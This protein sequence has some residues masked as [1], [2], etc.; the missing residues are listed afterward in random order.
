MGT[1]VAY[2]AGKLARDHPHVIEELKAGKYK[3]VHAAAIAAGVTPR[4]IKLSATPESFARQA[5]HYFD[6]AQIKTLI[7]LL[8]HPERLPHP[9]QRG[10]KARVPVPVAHAS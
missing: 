2:L 7:H 9:Q 5:H 3:S 4:T 10:P 1:S 8:R 6:A